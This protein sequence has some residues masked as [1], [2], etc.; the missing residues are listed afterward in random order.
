MAFMSWYSSF[1]LNRRLWWRSRFEV[2]FEPQH[3][4]KCRINFRERKKA[5]DLKIRHRHQIFLE[6]YLKLK[7]ETLAIT[8]LNY[9]ETMQHPTSKAF[10]VRERKW[11]GEAKTKDKYIR[12]ILFFWSFSYKVCG[13]KANH[14]RKWKYPAYHSMCTLGEHCP[15][16][17]FSN[18]HYFFNLFFLPTNCCFIAS[19][20]L[21]GNN[22]RRKQRRKNRF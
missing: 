5:F 3:E 1:E 21:L 10:R 2:L 8:R 9:V 11:N 7:M 14:Q 22:Q 6:S 12:C 20:P 15:Y 17:K 4:L 13:H 16:N 18:Y 19:L